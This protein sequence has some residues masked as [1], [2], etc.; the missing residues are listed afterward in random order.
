MVCATACQRHAILSP[1]PS[2]SPKC[3]C[4]I[5]RVIVVKKIRS[6]Q[7]RANGTPSYRPRTSTSPKCD[8]AIVRVI[9]V[10]K[11]RSAQPRAN[12]TPSY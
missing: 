12:G 9:V 11:I 2:T 5:E 3:G 8:R 4:A 10:K 6:A 7:Q 1:S